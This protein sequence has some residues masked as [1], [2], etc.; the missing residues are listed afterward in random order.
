MPTQGNASDSDN[1]AADKL[2]I[3][4]IIYDTQCRIKTLEAM[5]HSIK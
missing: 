1:G 5:V 2:I 3:S 4:S